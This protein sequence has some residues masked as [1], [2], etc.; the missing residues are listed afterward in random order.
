MGGWRQDDIASDSPILA[1]LRVLAKLR[2]MN[3]RFTITYVFNVV[4]S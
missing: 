4:V 3:P 1:F 2:S